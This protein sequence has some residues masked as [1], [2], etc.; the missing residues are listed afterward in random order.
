[1]TEQVN[2]TMNQEDFTA[3]PDLVFYLAKEDSKEYAEICST[4][5]SEHLQRARHAG[6]ETSPACKELAV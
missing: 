2:S 4:H 1:M 3:H 5:S 6:W